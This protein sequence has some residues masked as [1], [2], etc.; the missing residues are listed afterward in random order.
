MDR[1]DLEKLLNHLPIIVSTCDR[2]GWC[3]G[4]GVSIDPAVIPEIRLFFEYIQNFIPLADLPELEDTMGMPHGEITLLWETD[5]D[6]V[7]VTYDTFHIGFSG[8]GEMNYYG[9]LESIGTEIHGIV[10]LEAELDSDI[11]E[12]I[13][14]FQ[15]KQNE[16]QKIPE[17]TTPELNTYECL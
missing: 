11:I 12:H 9:K 10:P 14:F 2:Y 5:V 4:R 13:K 17:S 15:R 16:Q 3:G 7:T 6:P 8:T 1:K